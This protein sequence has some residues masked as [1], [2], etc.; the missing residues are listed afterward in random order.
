[1]TGEHRLP[2]G[3]IVYDPR[4]K[5]TAEPRELAA[6]LE[7]LDGIRLGVL[8]NTKWNASKLLRNVVDRLQG[9]LTL[10]AVNLYAKESFSRPA[11]AALLDRISAE[12]DAVITAIGD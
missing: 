10:A 3:R 1:M 12:N 7:T 4:G 6:R 8:D 11:E 5:V 2:D 9:D